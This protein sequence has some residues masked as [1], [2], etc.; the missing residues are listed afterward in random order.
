MTTRID[1]VND[2]LARLASLPL[3]AE[4]T[5]G[6]ADMAVRLYDETFAEVLT[7][8]DW[9]F[10]M[11]FVELARHAAAPVPAFWTYSYAL[12]S[13][14]HGPVQAFF[15]TERPEYST[16][17]FELATI[18]VHHA[19][20]AHEAVVFARCE[21]LWCRYK[22][23]PSPLFWTPGFRRAVTQLLAAE[24][25]SVMLEDHKRRE[26]LR[27]EVMGDPRAPGTAGLLHIARLEDMRGRP[28]PVIALAG[29]PLIE[30]R[31][32]SHAYSTDGRRL[33]R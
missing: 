4:E 8:A 1:I 12:P 33:W 13:D 15:E 25:A 30:V 32:A 14:R 27:Y 29:G 11:R 21:R 5:S 16:T 26:M 2:A 28:S 9:S 24:L 7:H 6:R 3:Q 20:G 18:L 19:T 23:R 22:S 10:A 17:D 31:G